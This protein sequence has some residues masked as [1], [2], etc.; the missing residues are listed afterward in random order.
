ME[1]LLL[2]LNLGTISLRNISQIVEFHLTCKKT[3]ANLEEIYYGIW[4]LTS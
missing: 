1:K 2:P 4:G 3:Y